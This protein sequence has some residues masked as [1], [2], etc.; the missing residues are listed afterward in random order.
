MKTLIVYDSKYGCAAT[1]AAALKDHLNEEGQ[2]DL[3]K[4]SSYQGQGSEMDL[5]DYDAVIIGGSIYI[6]KIQATVSKFCDI[7]RKALLTKKLG[8]F[9]CGMREGEEAEKE[10]ADNFPEDLRNIA[11]VKMVF[12]GTFDFKVMS[13]MDKMIAKKVAGVKASTSTVDP[14][15][16]HRFARTLAH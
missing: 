2:V 6:G 5:S 11:S 8:L 4:L 9:I 3:V 13:F 12:G 15:R 10:L 7:N 14:E 1:C 16:I